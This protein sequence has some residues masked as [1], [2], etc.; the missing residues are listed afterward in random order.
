MICHGQLLLNGLH[1]ETARWKRRVPRARFR[2]MHALHLIKAGRNTLRAWRN[3]FN[4]APSTFP[5]QPATANQHFIPLCRGAGEFL[6][7]QN[8]LL[9]NILLCQLSILKNSTA[10]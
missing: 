6:L 8:S 10:S 7:T 4:A 2:F 1:A 3:Q 9:R 5:Y